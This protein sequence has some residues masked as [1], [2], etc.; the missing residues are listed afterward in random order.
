MNTI[1]STLIAAAERFAFHAAVAFGRNAKR[2][3]ERASNAGVISAYP[4]TGALARASE[5]SDVQQ[6]DSLPLHTRSLREY[7]QDWFS[8]KKHPWVF[9]QVERV[10][11]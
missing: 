5:S 6:S 8:N 1:L 7:A 10:T 4:A 2:A 9:P 11:P 3:G